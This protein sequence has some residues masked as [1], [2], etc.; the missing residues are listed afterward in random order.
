L[1]KGYG[2]VGAA[3]EDIF[4]LLE[5]SRTEEYELVNEHFLGAIVCILGRYVPYAV[6]QYILISSSRRKVNWIEFIILEDR[7]GLCRF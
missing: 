5:K 7:I 4:S 6:P 3:L 2:T 1:S